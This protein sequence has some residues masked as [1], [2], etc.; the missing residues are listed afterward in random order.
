MRLRT[1][2]CSAFAINSLFKSE[3]VHRTFTPSSRDLMRH[4]H[5]LTLLSR[6]YLQTKSDKFDVLEKLEQAAPLLTSTK[7]QTIKR[8]KVLSKSRRRAENKMTFLEGHRLIIDT[9]ANPTVKNLYRDILVTK[10]ALQHRELGQTLSNRLEEVMTQGT[11]LVRLVSHEV[12]EAICDTV[13]PQGV[14]AILSLPKAYT[15]PSTPFE[16]KHRFYMILDGVS[17]PGNIGTLIRSSCAVGVD[18][19]ILLPNCCD[20]WS[21]KAIRSAMG[22]TFQVP[23]VKINGF[24]ECLEFLDRCDISPNNI[25]AA[26]MDENDDD[27]AKQNLSHSLPYYEV[28]WTADGKGSALCIGKEGSGLSSNVR[29]AIK[30]ETIRTVYV[31]MGPGIESLNAAVSGS[32]ILFEYRRQVKM[33]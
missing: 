26:T 32:V 33:C 19:V 31:P 28:N 24:R 29:D 16:K 17:D 9:L 11:C 15:P 8:Y 30:E 1:S 7:S 23:I 20:V 27:A 21:P 5:K 2:R 4:P 12:I 13:T 14:V 18:A 6:C 10:E 22:A 25:Y 3:V